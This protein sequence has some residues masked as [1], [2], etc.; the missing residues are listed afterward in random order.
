MIISYPEHINAIITRLL[1]SSHKAYI[2]GGCVRDHFLNKVPN[3]YDITT[4][5]LPEEVMRLF[6][7]CNVIPTGLKHGTVT[8]VVN[9]KPVEITTF[10]SDGEYTDHRHPSSV[11]FSH[12]FKDDAMRRDL[13]IN[14]MAYNS[15]EGV[16]DLFGGRAD[17]Q[18]KIIRTVGDPDRRFGEDALRILRALRF[19]SALDFEIEGRTSASIHNNK[20]LLHNI[21]AERIYSEFTRLLCGTGVRKVLTEYPDVI[22]CF[23]PEIISMIG[24]DQ[25][26]F[27]HIYDVW[28][29]TAVA[30]DHIKN[31]S[32]LRLAAFFHDIGKPQTYSLSQDGVGHFYGHSVVSEKIAHD[33]LKRLKADNETIAK[34][35]TLIKYHD[36]QIPEDK[37]IIRRHMA[38]LSPDVFFDLIE[39][40]RADTLALAPDYRGRETH[41]SSIEAIANEIMEEKPCLTVR[42]LAIDGN[43]IISLGIS[44][45]KQI[46]E[47]LNTLLE[48]VIAGNLPN[49]RQALMSMVQQTMTQSRK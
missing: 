4:D 29:H 33:V 20:D 35:T 19:S 45:G 39:M 11:D 37:R 6:S 47:I 30:V 5:A 32:I 43:D 31:T 40:F 26:N 21:S 14:A 12:D 44:P 46:G 23:I 2:V 18:N 34:V 10:R 8:V 38:K 15:V 22:A 48:L 49:T 7:D 1:S 41:F 42:S 17:I 9:G 24:F 27:H 36:L 3:D 16:I 25:H 28:Q 13:T